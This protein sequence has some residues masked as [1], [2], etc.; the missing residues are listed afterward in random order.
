MLTEKEISDLITLAKTNPDWLKGFPTMACT[1]RIPCVSCPVHVR[2]HRNELEEVCCGKSY[3]RFL[4][5]MDERDRLEIMV[6]LV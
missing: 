5:D 4:N 3:M 1:G 6:A 2:R